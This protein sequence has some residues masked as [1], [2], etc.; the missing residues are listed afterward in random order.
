MGQIGERAKLALEAIERGRIGGVQELESNGRAAF[1][2]EDFVDGAE[3]ALPEPSAK[4]EPR[5]AAEARSQAC[6]GRVAERPPAA[7]RTAASTCPLAASSDSTSRRNAS[8]PPQALSR[9]AARSSR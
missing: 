9:Y 8:S 4:L 6:T 3:P 1:A 5:R 7:R 2:V